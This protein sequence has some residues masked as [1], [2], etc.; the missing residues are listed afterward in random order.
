[1]ALICAVLWAISNVMAT[2]V[3]RQEGAL[4]LV[5]VRAALTTLSLLLLAPLILSWQDL[6]SLDWAT[7]LTFALGV[8]PLLGG[9]SVLFYMAGERIGVARAF[10]VS[11]TYPLLT[12]AA[13][14]LFLGERPTTWVLGGTLATVLGIGLLSTSKTKQESDAQPRSL[15]R[16]SGFWYA[17]LAAVLWAANTLLMKVG[18]GSGIHPVLGNLLRMPGVTV[19]VALVLLARGEKRSLWAVSARSWGILLAA[20]LMGQVVGDVLYLWALQLTDASLVTPLSATSPL[21]A[22][23]LA[24]I[25]LKEQLD[26]RVVLGVLLS[27]AGVVAIVA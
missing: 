25:F 20:T 26:W 2:P 12:T 10:A 8:A 18:L 6:T 3:S 7:I 13:A 19:L 22:V 24:R 16:G 1:M 17:V 11:S 23:P 21:W 15:L 27:V 4:R 5:G 9:G 14:I